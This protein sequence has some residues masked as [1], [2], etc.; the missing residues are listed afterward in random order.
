MA[1]VVPELVSGFAVTAAGPGVFVLD[2]APGDAALVDRVLAGP[3]GPGTLAELVAVDPAGLAG[4]D[5]VGLIQ[6]FERVAGLVAGHQ[7]VA[8]AAVVEATTALGLDGEAA[9]HEVGAAL[10][11]SPPV[12]AARTQVART[13]VHRLPAT[14]AALT[15]GRI[16]YLQAR[17]VAEAVTDLGLSDPA[18]AVVQARVLAVAAEQTLAETRRTLARAVLAADPAAADRR[19]AKARAGRGVELAPL[20]DGMCGM[21]ATL[22]APDAEH[23]HAHL[24]AHA[25]RAKRRLRAAGRPDPGLD[26][27]RADTLVALLTG[28]PL[29]GAGATGAGGAAARREPARNPATPGSAPSAPGPEQPGAGSGSPGS[30]LG[31]CTCGG[32]RATA[33]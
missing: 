30:G 12:A 7:Q 20:P 14:L 5:R 10:R 2:P 22:T 25:R 16:G 17:A 6:A 8:L 33:V 4:P 28:R 9:R 27:L 32:R 24:T 18:A 26:A 1:G 11:L 13:L 21:W 23:A 3:L 19:L 31:R 29:P 15:A